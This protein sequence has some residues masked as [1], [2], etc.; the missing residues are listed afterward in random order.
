MQRCCWSIF[1][2]PA[3]HI[4]LHF[5]ARF[6]SFMTVKLT[7]LSRRFHYN[8]Y[9]WIELALYKKNKYNCA[10]AAVLLDADV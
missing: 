7:L 5:H 8:W 6:N 1:F 9:P 4:Y 10:A 2:F 3:K